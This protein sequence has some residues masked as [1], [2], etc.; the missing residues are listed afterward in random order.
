[1]NVDD[2]PSFLLFHLEI[3]VHIMMSSSWFSE[4]HQDEESYSTWISCFSFFVFRQRSQ[5]D[6]FFV[7]LM[8]SGGHAMFEDE[9]EGR[10]VQKLEDWPD[11]LNKKDLS[12]QPTE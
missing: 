12:I 10:S 9:N 3:W 6:V 11:F 1:M 4:I 2:V 7:R 8:A 5:P